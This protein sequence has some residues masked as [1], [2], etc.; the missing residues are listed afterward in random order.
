[1]AEQRIKY[2]ETFHSWGQEG[3]PTIPTFY[4]KHPSGARGNWL[5][6]FYPK[7]AIK[8]LN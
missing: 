7:K 5:K 8:P 6:E 2:C 1:L 3:H 4:T